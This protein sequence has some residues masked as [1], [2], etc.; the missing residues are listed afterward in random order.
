MNTPL[1]LTPAGKKITSQMEDAVN[2]AQRNAGQRFLK[3]FRAKLR[4]H[5]TRNHIITIEGGMGQY[6]VCINGKSVGWDCGAYTWK[7][8]PVF[9]LLQDIQ[10]SLVS[11]WDWSLEG[12]HLN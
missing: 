12:E 9:K 11:D 3:L 4:K 8:C 6:S 10:D 5:N 1:G 7:K 2:K